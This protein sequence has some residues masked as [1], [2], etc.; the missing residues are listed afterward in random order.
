MEE[1]R[2]N[3]EIGSSLEAKLVLTLP[4]DL[5]QKLARL[6]E[7][8]QQEFFIVSQLEIKTGPEILVEVQKATGEKCPRCWN[9][10]TLVETSGYGE[11]CPKCNEAL[12]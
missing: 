10:A 11:L 1:S 9:Y 3:K 5:K 12:T 7:R 6:T 8:Q 4:E 2:A